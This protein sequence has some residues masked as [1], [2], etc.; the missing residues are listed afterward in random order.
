M[1]SSKTTPEQKYSQT[2][3][4]VYLSGNQALVRLV[5]EQHRRDRE[6]G[7]NTGGFISGYRG[8]P[9]G[10]LDQDF[11]RVKPLL[12]ERDIRFQPGVNEDMAA[13]AVW[14]TQQI[15]FF[16][17]NFD[18]VFG[19]WYSKGP[20]ID[21]S[22][23]A[24]R[25]ANLWGTAPKGGVVMAVGDDPMARSS[26]IQQQSEHT[27]ASMCIPVF[28]AAN[29]QDIY[30]YGLIGWQLSRIAGVWT[31]VKS[32]SDIFESWLAI[33]VDPARWAIQ[34]P[35][36]PGAV[37]TRWPDRSVD[38]D[39][40]ML[41]L[42][43]PAVREF[44]R[45]NRL[46]RTTHVSSQRRIGIVATGKAWS[47]TVEAL[48]D[49]GL[50]EA[51]LAEIGVEI[52]K[53]ALVWPLEPETLGEFVSGLEEVLVVEESR[54][55]LEPQIASI[56][57]NM[58]AEQRPRLLGKRNDTGEEWMPSHGELTPVIIA[59][60]LHR[61]IGRLHRSEAMDRWIAYLDQVADELAQ[62]RTNVIRSPYFCSG[63]PHSSSTKVP[64]GSQQ[65]AGIGCHWM[66]NLMDRETVTYPQMGGEGANWAGAAHFLKDEHIF[67]NVGDGTW[68]HSGSLAIR[69]AVAAGV[70][71]TYKILYNDAVAMTGGQ[72]ID[73]PISVAQMTHEL[74]GEAVGR[75]VV[76][77][78]DP[79]KFDVA[80]F[81]AGTDLYHRDDLEKVQRELRQVKGVSVIIYE[82]T[83]A[84]ELR[85]R[86]GKGIAP[87]PQR[88]AFINERVCEGC[89]DC[90]VQSNCLSVQPLETEF[91]RKRVIDQSACNKDFSCIKGFCPSFVTIEGGSL[92]RPAASSSDEFAD[93]DLPE[94]DTQSIDGVFGMM[95]AGIGGTGVVTISN[96]VGAAAQAEG[97]AIQA[98]DL[99]GLAQK[100]GAVHCHL[101]VAND[102]SALRSTRLSVGQCDVMIG[103]DIVTAASDDAL[104]RVRR[105]Y[106]RAVVNDHEA[107]TGEFTR[108][109]EFHIPVEDQK[110]AIERFC[111][112]G[113]AEFVEA[114]EI[115]ER[116][117]GNTIGANVMLLGFACQKG[118]LPVKLASL[119]SAI[120]ENGVAVDA[121][122]RVFHLGRVL[123]H[124]PEAIRKTVES[125][126]SISL[127][128]SLSET[129]DELVERRRRDLIAY[130]DGAYSDRYAVQ[131]ERIRK[132][133]QDALPG[134]TALAEAFAR[135][136]YK[137]LAY[138]DEY[139]VARLYT[140][141]RFQQS[142]E[143][144]F[145]GDY[146]IKFHMAPPLLAKIDE[147]SGRPRKRAFGPWLLH[148]LRLL[149]R[150][151]HLRGTAFDPFGR[152][153]ERRLERQLISDYEADGE[154]VLKELRGAK[155]EAALQLLTWPDAVRGYGPVKELSIHGARADRARLREEFVS[156]EPRGGQAVIEVQTS[157][158]QMAG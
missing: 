15:G 132:A 57:V 153:A 72:P 75:T 98:L 144:Q 125:G 141:G 47:D 50:D 79:S 78:S 27:L 139:E 85:R 89:G 108:D 90:S 120:R 154:L 151:K 100:F 110:R 113:Q 87:D 4:R 129:V 133:E 118:W 127:D 36:D 37:H 128:L 92:V 11:T 96:L 21:R 147:T 102:H 64:D 33:N 105:D 146:K 38:Q 10:H 94:P 134:A 9:L 46:N 88:R 14:G 69:Q 8:S 131:V 28:N 142:L 51:I 5:F 73:G 3:G 1:A 20:G 121:N 31:A 77:S 34:L 6:A 109:R 43:L 52:F 126:A 60:V 152:S 83:C 80:D 22:G 150:L 91:G 56:L 99:T 145:G 156:A 30:D 35:P 76:V 44:A 48:S 53:V 130:Q 16:K 104:S 103:A 54:P 84:T 115:A 65:L 17:P 155:Y 93:I 58:P 40:R 107:V 82:Q 49:L 19:M 55:F 143:K 23:D 74:R 111:G 13:T 18:G 7:L 101:K 81:A 24:L 68:Y 66:V 45:L 70:T 119:L 12:E 138:K 117:T 135:N 41:M 148:G 116:L 136:Y 158:N 95:V 26:S 157:K 42:R 2:D 149:A 71:M 114:T 39:E 123:A 86:R 137:L 63:C 122:L 62:P 59:R 140:D 29:V 97:L 106:T 67:A 124:D 32:V 25:H 112:E 61:W